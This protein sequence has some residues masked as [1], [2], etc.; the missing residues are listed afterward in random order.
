M[1]CRFA[2]SLR[3]HWL[4]AHADKLEFEII[5]PQKNT[6]FKKG[7]PFCVLSMYNKISIL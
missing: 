6:F 2:T 7:L 5:L 4:S 3:T 1:V